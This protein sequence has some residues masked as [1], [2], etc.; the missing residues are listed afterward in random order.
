MRLL[1][2]FILIWFLTQ[3][4][5][6]QECTD[7][8]QPKKQIVANTLLCPDAMNADLTQLHKHIL[9][10]HPNPKQALSDGANAIQLD[11][12]EDLINDLVILQQAV[13]KL[14]S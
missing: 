8:F 2:S 5:H 9:E 11:R 14:K 1:T 12:V 10:T 7:N 6:S 3:N 4:V 13:N